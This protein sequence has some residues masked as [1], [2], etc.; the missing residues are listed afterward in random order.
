MKDERLFK[1]KFYETCILMPILTV[2]VFCEE[3]LTT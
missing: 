1:A 2:E 3:V